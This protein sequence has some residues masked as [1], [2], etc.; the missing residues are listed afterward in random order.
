MKTKYLILS[1]LSAVLLAILCACGDNGGTTD[2]TTTGGGSSEAPETGSGEAVCTDGTVSVFSP[3]G[4][5]RMKVYKNTGGNVVYTLDSIGSGESYEVIGESAMGVK[6]SDADGFSDCEIISCESRV[7]DLTFAYL[8][9]VSSVTDRCTAAKIALRSGDYD[10]YIEI[11]LYDNGAAFRYNMPATGKSRTI[12]SE[13]TTFTVNDI[14]KVW[15]GSGS[16]CYESEIVSST[17]ADVTTSAKLNAPITIELKKSRGYVVLAEGYV[18]DSYIGTNYASTGKKNT[19]KIAG[20]WN[21]RTTFEKFSAEGDVRTGWRLINYAPDLAGIV[22]NY[23][24][25]SSALDFDSDTVPD[26]IADWIVPGKSTWSWIN[27]GSVPFD[28]QIDYTVYCS[29]LGFTYNIIDEGYT[30]WESSTDKLQELGELGEELNVKQILWMFVT[31]GHAGYQISSVESAARMISR[32]AS[33]KMAGIKLDFFDSESN[34]STLAI[35]KETLLQT[36]KKQLIVDFHGVHAP[37]SL[38]VQYP[39]ELS[40]E[41]IR[42]LE[43]GLRGNYAVQAKYITAQYYTRLLAG[44]ADFTPDVNTAMQI[45]SL[46][47]LDSPL[48][49]IATD[50]AL[51]L[52][53]E[54]LEMI[55]AIPTVW[56]YTVFLDGKIGSYVSVAKQKDGVWY[57]GGIA[58]DTVNN[59]KIDLSKFLGDGE[60]LLTL[61]TDKSTSQKALTEKTVT[62]TDVVEIGKLTAGLGYVAQITKLDIGQHGG[63]ISAPI[64]VKTAGKDSVVKYTTDGSD[65]ANSGTAKVSDGAIALSDSCLLRVAIVS[66][67]GEGSEMSYYFNKVEYNRA[68]I[69]AEYGD[70][71][72]VV[73]I[74]SSLDGAKIYYTTDGNAPTTSSTLYTSPLTIKSETT[75]KA[76]SVSADGAKTS[77]AATQKVTVRFSVHAIDPDVYLGKNYVEAVAGWDNRICVDQS[78]N[79]TTISLGGTNTS[80]GTKFEHGISTNAIGYFVYDI[81]SSATRFVGVAGIDDSSFANSTDGYRASIVCIISIDGK[82]VYRTQKLG[83][84]QYEQI[85]VEIPE[86]ASQ[87]RIYFGDAGDGITCDNAS[88]ANAGFIY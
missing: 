39:N 44:H 58:S 23:N 52:E 68:K 8:G 84:G 42:G 46:V 67:D 86:G 5:M 79:Y 83:Q 71:E 25:Y 20:S 34:P 27:D 59:A 82:E 69:E 13:L 64:T 30:N 51:M 35:E 28:P 70:G 11:K 65:P 36:A 3:S 57:V 72:T 7:R 9:S 12:S 47:V 74:F 38:S 54:A 41:G 62:S 37:V 43:Q 77:A 17:Y 55:K 2:V 85:D 1:L 88:L 78:M 73:S 60:Y 87:I 24:I 22:C 76:I 56:D 48:M 81:P 18:D 29:K 50:P 75:I 26:G 33:Y 66:G 6:I 10:F 53:N 15:Y 61:W 63:E 40:R 32:V 49:V 4:Y 31:G 45:G 16:D 21:A 14:S 19:F 80:N